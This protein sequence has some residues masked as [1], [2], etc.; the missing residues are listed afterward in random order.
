MSLKMGYVQAWERYTMPLVQTARGSLW[1]ADQRTPGSTLPALLLVHGAGGSRLQ[2][3]AALRRLAGVGVLALDLPGHDRSPGPPRDTIDGYA[4]DIAALLDA[5]AIDAAYVLGHS[6]GG[7]AALAL[8]LAAP[9]R[10]RGLV[11]V[12]SG[13]R[14]AVSPEMLN[15]AEAEAARLLVAWSWGP[16][17]DPLLQQKHLQALLA[18]PDGTLHADLT[19]CNRFDVRDRLDEIS[20]PALVVAG[21]FDRM[22]PPRYSAYLQTHLPNAQAVTLDSGHM[23]MLEQPDALAEAVSLWLQNR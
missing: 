13:A 8:A 6:L 2:W 10:V 14:L 9:D 23:L 17:A 21:A 3:P 5:L 20:A 15:A 22:T 19:A 4:A 16:N 12:G 7:A 1:V 11:L 18:L